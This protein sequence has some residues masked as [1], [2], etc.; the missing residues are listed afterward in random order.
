MR[1]G[2]AD[3]SFPI[4]EAGPH[5]GLWIEWLAQDRKGSRWDRDLPFD[6]QPVSRNLC[7]LLWGH[8]DVA[9]RNHLRAAIG[10]NP[11]AEWIVAPVLL[12]QPVQRQLVARRKM[13]RQPV[14]AGLVGIERLA[15][16]FAVHPGLARDI[17]RLVVDGERA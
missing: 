9:A 14:P 11:I 4:G 13:Q 1:P 17:D 15:A 3:R 16:P 8:L 5:P 7:R 2:E 12:P 10:E 6:R